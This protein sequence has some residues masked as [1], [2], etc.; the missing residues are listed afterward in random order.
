MAAAAVTAV[1][2]AA[3]AAGFHYRPKVIQA[4]KRVVIMSPAVQEIVFIELN[5]NYFWDM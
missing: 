1:A 3:A 5:I 4:E 2:A